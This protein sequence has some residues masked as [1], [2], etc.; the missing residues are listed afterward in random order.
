MQ[1]KRFEL[2]ISWIETWWHPKY[3]KLKRTCHVDVQYEEI[4]VYLPVVP[5]IVNEFR[6]AD[7][8]ICVSFGVNLGSRRQFDTKKSWGGLYIEINVNYLW[9]NVE[10]WSAILKA[11]IAYVDEK[12]WLQKK[13][14]SQRKAS[15]YLWAISTKESVIKH[16]NL[17]AVHDIE[18]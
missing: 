18:K 9:V 13:R 15:L 3:K 11:W 2:E 10:Y 4:D 5:V 1:A 7:G 6:C 16:K 14:H 17:K 8:L 12:G